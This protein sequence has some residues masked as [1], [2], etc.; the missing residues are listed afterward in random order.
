MQSV[1]ED[2]WKGKFICGFRAMAHLC[3]QCKMWSSRKS[4]GV[5]SKRSLNMRIYG[6]L[7]QAFILW[8][9][10]TSSRFSGWG[11]PCQSRGSFWSGSMALWFHMSESL[12]LWD[13][14]GIV[15]RWLCARCSSAGP[16]VVLG[17]RGAGLWCCPLSSAAAVASRHC[18]GMAQGVYLEFLL[19]CSDSF[20]TN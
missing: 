6:K 18:P 4:W 14:V 13:F 5:A 2:L 9:D 19:Q 15:S 16:R 12:W 17:C 8:N 11:C 7:P 1:K 10:M 3:C 20:R